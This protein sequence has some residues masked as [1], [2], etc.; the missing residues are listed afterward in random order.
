MQCV[1][2]NTKRTVM[3][4]TTTIAKVGGVKMTRKRRRNEIT[5]QNVFRRSAREWL[6]MKTKNLAKT[7]TRRDKVLL[8]SDYYDNQGWGCLRKCW[9]G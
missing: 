2:L 5:L 1:I 4:L 3:L 7:Y 8:E 6:Y 9:L